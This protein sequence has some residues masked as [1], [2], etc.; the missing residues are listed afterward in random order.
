METGSIVSQRLSIRAVLKEAWTLVRGTKLAVLVTLL[1]MVFVALIVFMV[2]SKVQVDVHTNYWTG[3]A[4]NLI[5]P[6][7]DSLCLSVFLAGLAMIGLK[8]ARHEAI[9]FSEGLQYFGKLPKIVTISYLESLAI[10]L[11]NN[12]AIFAVA[13]LLVKSAS[14]QSTTVMAAITLGVA[15]LLTM[16]IKTFLSFSFQFALDKQL[17]VISAIGS[18]IK[19]ISHH[20]WK[21][22]LLIIILALINFVGACLAGIG[23]FWTVPLAYNSIGILYRE[24]VDKSAAA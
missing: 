13:F 23:L 11:I 16:L 3:L 7:I 2:L 19:L 1:P 6:L 21:I 14:I 12:L 20:Y 17:S 5:S 24:L 4:Y 8:R 15:L 10:L 18:S 22:F 9:R